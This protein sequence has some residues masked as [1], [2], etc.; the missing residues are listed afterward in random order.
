MKS[1]ANS[2]WVQGN[3]VFSLNG[4]LIADSET[5]KQELWKIQQSEVGLEALQAAG[6]AVTLASA[7]EERT[8]QETFE[9]ETCHQ[10]FLSE[11]SLGVHK[12]LHV[13]PRK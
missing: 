6:L 10:T 7:E 2:Y 5:S 11:R 8:G 13:A 3:R 1:E 12:K 9:C 4:T